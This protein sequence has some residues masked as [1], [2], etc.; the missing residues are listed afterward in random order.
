MNIIETWESLD[1]AIAVAAVLAE[2]RAR[3]EEYRD[4][5]D[6]EDLA[7]FVILQPGEMIETLVS[8]EYVTEH[9]G[10]AVS[11]FVYADDGYGAVVIALT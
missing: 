3:L 5:Y 11:V 4:T 7:R 8:P 9:I 10:F 1:R 6:L 2:H